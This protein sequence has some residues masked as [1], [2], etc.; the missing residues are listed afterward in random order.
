MTKTPKAARSDKAA[1]MVSVFDGRRCL[2]FVLPKGKSG[3]EATTADDRLLG[4]FPSQK[5]A[6][7]AISKVAGSIV[8]DIVE[9]HQS[10]EA[11]P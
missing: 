9:E 6:A 10:S 11:A 7:D 4:L 2:G 3:F 5:E 8:A 1:P